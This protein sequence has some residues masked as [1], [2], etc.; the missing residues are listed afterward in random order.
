VVVCRL[1]RTPLLIHRALLKGNDL[2]TTMEALIKFYSTWSIPSGAK[3][4][5]ALIAFSAVR[6]EALT[7]QPCPFKTSTYS[8]VPYEILHAALYSENA[9]GP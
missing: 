6:A 5:A 2:Q 8:E 4:P 9:L 1:E 7:Y 3:A